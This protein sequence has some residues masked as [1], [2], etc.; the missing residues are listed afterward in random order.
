[1]ELAAVA[2]REE[3]HV[4][5][6]E[7]SPHFVCSRGTKEGK[8][9]MK[10]YGIYMDGKKSGSIK[11]NDIHGYASRIFPQGYEIDGNKLNVGSITLGQA[12][13]IAMKKAEDK[14]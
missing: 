9:V 5:R 12:M 11:T 10:T 1:M 8:N 6:I 3:I 7:N 14:G 13:A 4:R 2:L